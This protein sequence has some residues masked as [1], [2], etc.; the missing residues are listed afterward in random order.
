[1]DINA[2]LNA[3][4]PFADNFV[5]IAG[6]IAV[7]IALYEHHRNKGFSKNEKIVGVIILIVFIVLAGIEPWNNLYNPQ[8]IYEYATS[9]SPS[10][11]DPLSAQ[12][13]NNWE[14]VTNGSFA[15]LFIGRAYHAS[16]SQPSTVALCL[17]HATN[18]SNF[19]FQVQMT[20]TNGDAGGLVFRA[21]E[22][23]H[24]YRFTVHANGLYELYVSQS[25]SGRSQTLA[26]GHVDINPYQNNLLTVI[27]RDTHIYLYVNRK[28]LVDA[29]DSA[30]SFGEI[31]VFGYDTANPTDVAFRNAQAWAL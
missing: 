4:G 17:A 11:N 24:L 26:Y 18:F 3:L 8:S 29:N 16:S 2:F 25:S 7:I 22:N 15:C 23:S 13:T 27:A 10:L 9:G 12:D 21:D 28:F 1:M 5:K 19:A 6:P 30:F 20:I 14:E 31:G